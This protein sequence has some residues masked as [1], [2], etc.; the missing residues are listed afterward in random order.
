MKSDMISDNF[1]LFP[2]LIKAV[3]MPPYLSD[4]PTPEQIDDL[5]SI[6]YLMNETRNQATNWSPL[7][8]IKFDNEQPYNEINLKSEMKKQW[9]YYLENDE[10]IDL[11]MNNYG[12][13]IT[14]AGS[15]FAKMVPDYEYFACRFAPQYPALFVRENLQKC[16]DKD[17]YRC[18]EAIKIVREN[19][20]KCVDEVLLR[21]YN[22]FSSTGR[23]QNNKKTPFA[24]LYNINSPYKWIY[25]ASRQSTL[26]PHPWRILNH[27][28]GY[29]QHYMEYVDS[30]S[31]DE[32]TEIDK[33]H[34]VKGVKIE[35]EKYKEKL[36]TISTERK[37]YYNN[38]T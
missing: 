29:L 12:V 8:M 27:Q 25:M 34:I 23:Y 10:N 1:L 35:I 22:F 13:R 4:R 33:L 30:L 36:K 3:L 38:F 7:I 6:L 16:S 2:Q 14:S 32:I 31:R 17:S 15:F 18:L 20:F 19:A 9:N 21:D 5:S 11:R 28:L 37:D 26:I 24:L